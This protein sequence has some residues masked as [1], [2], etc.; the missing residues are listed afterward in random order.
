M[1]Q[2]IR[3]SE[4]DMLV[5]QKCLNDGK[6]KDPVPRGDKTFVQ[7]VYVSQSIQCRVNENR[8]LLQRSC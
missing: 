4:E 1:T 6:Q 5:L 7:S 8:R 2:E 3:L